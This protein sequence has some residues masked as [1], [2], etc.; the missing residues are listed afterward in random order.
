M[1]VATSVRLSGVGCVCLF[2]G[3]D[4]IYI[5]VVSLVG[6]F[7]LSLRREGGRNGT[8]LRM[9]P[10]IMTATAACSH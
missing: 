10:L 7:L 2:R 5:T 3:G 1:S 6:S 9:N 8:V 4:T